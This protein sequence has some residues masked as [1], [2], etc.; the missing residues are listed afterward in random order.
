VG[1]HSFG[2]SLESVERIHSLDRICLITVNEIGFKCLKSKHFPAKYIYFCP[3]PVESATTEPKSTEGQSES[4][5]EQIATL[6]DQFDLTVL[7]PTDDNLPEI[8]KSQV[9]QWFPAL[10]R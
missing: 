4:K 6:T 3:K 7:T 5:E 10:N 9:S 8:I 1:S 2:T